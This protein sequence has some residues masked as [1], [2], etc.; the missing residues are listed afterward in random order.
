VSTTEPGHDGPNVIVVDDHQL[1]GVIVARELR[2]RG[3]QADY[4]AFTDVARVLGAASRSRPGLVLLDLELGSDPDGNRID[5]LE[6]V[7]G[8]QDLGWSVLVVSGETDDRRV[9]AAIAAGAVGFVPKAAQLLDL[10]ETV[11]GVLDARP[12]LSASDR[13]RWLDIDRRSRRAERQDR[14][15]LRR[16]TAREREVL[17]LLAQGERASAIA[18][19]SVVSL[20]TVRS[21]IRSILMKL[22]VNSQLEA[23]A[24][25]RRTRGTEPP[26]GPRGSRRD[27]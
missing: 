20:L 3:V 9:A 21:Q 27:A 14:A 26:S 5:E 17:D 11:L 25:L 23:V 10:T 7:T 24:L 1:V 6:I 18:D 2:Q 12:V 15:C 19:R 13:K 8:L 22:D 4:C 16:L